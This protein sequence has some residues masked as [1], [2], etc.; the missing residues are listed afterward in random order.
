M[1]ND[2]CLLSGEYERRGS[3]QAGGAVEGDGRA[4]KVDDKQTN[5]TKLTTCFY[6]VAGI[7][8]ALNK[9]RLPR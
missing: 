7:C 1:I 3:E 8:A 9:S 5:H 6:V 2:K 4:V